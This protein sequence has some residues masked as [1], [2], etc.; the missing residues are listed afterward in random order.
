MMFGGP[1]C[2]AVPDSMAA[3]EYFPAANDAVESPIDFRNFRRF[4]IVAYCI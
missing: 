2:L 4:N 3:A 1:F